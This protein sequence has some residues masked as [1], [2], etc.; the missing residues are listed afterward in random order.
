MPQKVALA[1]S[2]GGPRGFAY[3]GA[4]EELQRRGYE[5]TSVSGCSI[6]SLVGGVFA[7]GGISGFKEWLLSLDHMKVMSLMDVSISKSYLVKGEKVIR[8]IK[9][10]VPD[11]N[12]QDLPIPYCAVAADL[13]TGEEVVFREGKLF[14]AIRAS[15][16]IPSMFKPVQY[17]HRTLVDGGIVNT[18]PLNIISR[19]EGDILIGFDVNTVN[20]D[21]INSFLAVLH[22]QDIEQSS[23]ESSAREKF[24]EIL[25]TSGLSPLEKV[26]LAG[27]CG[28]EMARHLY[29]VKG[30]KRDMVKAGRKEKLPVGSA[31]NYFSILSRCFSIANH[32]IAKYNAITCPPDILVSMPFDTYQSISDYGKAS[33]II[34]KG[35]E[36]MAQ[37]LDRYEKALPSE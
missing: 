23:I 34:E 28:S 18:L 32:V 10:I 17:G 33:E 15:I 4:I 11:V 20:T 22:G 6:G 30:H 12:I 37:A 19:T 35:R 14:D 16:S 8:A 3:I 13:Y 31:D 26:V 1:L 36:L 24:Q 7:A 27:G 5:I 2:S 25:S 21:A 9:E 29:D